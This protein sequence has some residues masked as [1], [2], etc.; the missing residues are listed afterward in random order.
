M[1]NPRLKEK[2]AAD[3]HD[4]LAVDFI[5]QAI[6]DYTGFFFLILCNYL[7]I[8]HCYEVSDPWENTIDSI[9]K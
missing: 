3:L 4:K 7:M 5:G 1:S 9:Q 6:F 2:P 8:V